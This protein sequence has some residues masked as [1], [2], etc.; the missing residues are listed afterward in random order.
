MQSNWGL[1]L[2]PKKKKVQHKEK[3]DTQVDIQKLL[4]IHDKFI[5]KRS[6]IFV[7]VN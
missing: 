6:P 5:M 4:A 2:R 7:K 3:A 1:R